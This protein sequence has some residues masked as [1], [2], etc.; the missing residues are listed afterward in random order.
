MAGSVTTTPSSRLASRDV[1]E[2]FSDPTK[3]SFRSA[4][5]ILAWM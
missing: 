4:T 1:R 5:I 2:K 3:A